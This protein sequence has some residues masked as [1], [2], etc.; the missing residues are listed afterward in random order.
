MR[1][2][3]CSSDNGWFT[4]VKTWQ[5]TDDERTRDDHVGLDGR[6]AVG[7]DSHFVCRSGD[8]IR[9]PH[10]PL[11]PA[12]QTINCRCTVKWT[13]VPRATAPRLVAEGV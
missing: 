3:K 1:C 13:L 9:Y 6:Q 8:T 11:A 10:D 12:R 4:V 7:I 2:I 5:A